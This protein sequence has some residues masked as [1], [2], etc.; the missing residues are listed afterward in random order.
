ME[1]TSV[2]LAP[3]PDRPNASRQRAVR[4]GLPHL[5]L[6]QDRALGDISPCLAP[7]TTLHEHVSLILAQRPRNPIVLPRGASAAAPRERLA[8]RRIDSEL[9]EVRRLGEIDVP[10]LVRG[11]V[12]Q[13]Q[14]VEREDAEEHEVEDVLVL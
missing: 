11:E 12:H 2:L 6:R 9:E 1:E 5:S 14:E 8:G 13:G 10:R 7:G 4:H 3:A